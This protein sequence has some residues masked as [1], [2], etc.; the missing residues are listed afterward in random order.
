[1]LFIEIL[2]IGLVSL[3]VGLLSGVGISQLTSLLVANMFE[4]DMSSYN[5]VFSSSAFV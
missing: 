4:A 3:G 1:M 5:F 2:F